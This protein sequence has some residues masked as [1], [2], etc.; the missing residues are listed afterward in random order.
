MIV[1]TAKIL[2][3]CTNSNLRTDVTALYEIHNTGGFF[4]Q[5]VSC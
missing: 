3:V 2:R 1:D 4:E 5:H